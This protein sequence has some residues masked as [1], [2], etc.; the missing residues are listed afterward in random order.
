M[1]VSL[2]QYKALLITYLKPQWFKV[3]VLCVL[4]LISI[5]MQIINPRIVRVF[6]DSA[7]NHASSQELF[8]IGLLFLGVAVAGHIITVFP[9]YLSEIVGRTA[10]DALRQDLVLH[11]LRMDLPFHH[12]HTPGQLIERVDGDVAA[13][14]NFFSQF[15]IRVFGNS[16]LLLAILVLLFLED[17]RVGAALSLYALGALFLLTRKRRSAVPYLQE[18]RQAAAHVTGFWEEHVS[19]TLDVRANG[20]IPYVM[21]RQYKLLALLLQKKR[22]AAL[23]F[24]GFRGVWILALLIGTVVSLAS[25]TALYNAG[26][27]TLGSVYMIYYYTNQLSWNLEAITMQMNDLQ[28]ATASIQRINAFYHLKSAITDGTGGALPPGPLSVAFNN[29]SFSYVRANTRLNTTDPAAEKDLTLRSLSF[30]LEPGKILGLLGRTGSGKT[31]ITRLLFRFY[32]PI[33]GAI[34]VGDRDIR[35]IPLASLRSS[36]GLITQEVQ[37]LHASIRDNL[38]FYKAEIADEKIL[39]V[40]HELGMQEWYARLPQ[41]LDTVLQPGGGGLS[42]GEAQLLAFTR[43]FLQDPGIVIL[44]EASSR[45]DPATER[46]IERA[47]DRLLHNRTGIIIAHRLATI[48]RA[49]TI[50]ILEDGGVCEY[51]ARQDLLDDPSS[52]FVQLLRLGFEEAPA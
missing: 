41:G 47:V 27:L 11:A 32:D 15:I 51:G 50:L 36:I 9:T 43:I 8:T 46:L 1:L 18:E 34:Q 25:S 24:V 31:T 44:D 40:I 2:R 16:L 20:A 21:L 39:A 28:Q 33:S 23:M 12:T 19:G 5:G 6:I 17:W 38:T 35:D 22:K 13:L 4:L 26:L 37:L 29:V 7:K 52:H 45:L 14:S 30:Q 48:Q 10:T 49:D 42:A 3:I